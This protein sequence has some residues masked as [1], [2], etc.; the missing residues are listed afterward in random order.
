MFR[1]VEMLRRVLILRGIAAA[2]VPALAAEAQ[3]NPHVSHLEAL[4][5]A[6]RPRLHIEHLIQ[7]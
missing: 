5:A 6:T 7:V 3:V 2:H 4:F 1:L